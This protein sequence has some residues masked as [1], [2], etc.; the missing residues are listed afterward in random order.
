MDNNIQI[1]SRVLLKIQTNTYL[2]GTVEEYKILEL[3][4]SMNWV[5]LQNIYGN[6][7]WKPL[8]EIA[9]VETLKHFEKCPVGKD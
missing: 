5:K 1:G 7:F 2:K 6:K 3:S 4:P 9:L 8:A